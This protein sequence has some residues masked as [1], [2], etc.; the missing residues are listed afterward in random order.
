[1]RKSGFPLR[2]VA[3][4]LVA[5]LLAGNVAAQKKK[6]DEAPPPGGIDAAT[7]KI[8]LRVPENAGRIT[9]FALAGSQLSEP[10]EVDIDWIAQAVQPPVAAPAKRL[11]VLSIGVSE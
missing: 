2:V 7:G 11:F 6:D 8:I 5:F 9:L 3:S 4:L 10:V 1:M